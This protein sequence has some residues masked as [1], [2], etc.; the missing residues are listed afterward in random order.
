MGLRVVRLLRRPWTSS[1]VGGGLLCIV[2]PE[3]MQS[4]GGGGMGGEAHR[5]AHACALDMQPLAHVAVGRQER[6]R[7]ERAA[8]RD[9]LPG[10]HKAAAI[11]GDVV[12]CLQRVLGV[13]DRARAR[14]AQHAQD[15]HR[16]GERSEQRGEPP[17]LPG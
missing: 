3:R 15:A 16:A 5:R 9:V 8:V 14:H 12:Q 11:R 10:G 1:S 17:G 4:W 13:R 2:R 6:K 7:G